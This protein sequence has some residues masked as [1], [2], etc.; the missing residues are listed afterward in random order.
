M[1]KKPMTTQRKKRILKDKM[2]KLIQQIFVPKNP[3]C[4]I[5]GEPTSEGHHFVQKTQSMY[6]RW[7]EKNLIQLC[8]A[9]HCRHHFSGDPAIVANI[10]KIMGQTWFM[11]I[12]E[13]RNNPFNDNL[14]NLRELYNELQKQRMLEC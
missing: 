3:R 7:N 13:N 4:L 10:V 14:T 12:Q 11:W 1:K 6:L 5:C 8:R 9:C 2:D